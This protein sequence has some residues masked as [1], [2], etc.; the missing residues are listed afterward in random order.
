MACIILPGVNVEWLRW[1]GLANEEATTVT[2]QRENY[3]HSNG[4]D[5]RA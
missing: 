5:E 4:R 1:R 3:R 2:L